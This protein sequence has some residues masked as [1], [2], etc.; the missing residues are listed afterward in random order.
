MSGL[1]SLISGIIF[2]IGLGI[3][4]MVDPNVVFG[5]LDLFGNWNPALVFVM[6]GAIAF[7]IVPFTLIK[8]K[9]KTFSGEE[10]HLPTN[11]T[12]DKKLVIGSMMFGIGSGLA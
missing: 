11:K 3:S 8:K 4:G 12:I 9:K 1:I 7:A 6:V 10:I 2:S 5:F